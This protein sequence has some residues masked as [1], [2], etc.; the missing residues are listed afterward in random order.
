LCCW[1]LAFLPILVSLC[2][3][4]WNLYVL[5]CTMRH[6][7]ILG[8]QTI[9]LEL[10]DCHVFCYQNNGKSSNSGNYR[11]IIY[12]IKVSI[13]RIKNSQ[14]SRLP[15]FVYIATIT[16]IARFILMTPRTLGNSLRN[17][18]LACPRR[19]STLLTFLGSPI[20]DRVCS[21][22]LYIFI[23]NWTTT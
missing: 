4:S 12:R 14:N 18:R 11:T 2:Y 3:C 7:V 15:S 10:L 19:T 5:Y 6:I 13:Y 8:N 22:P 17:R 21:R 23:Y 16:W 9:G 20:S 1:R